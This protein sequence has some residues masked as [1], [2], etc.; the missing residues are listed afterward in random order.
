[1][2]TQEQLAFMCDDPDRFVPGAPVYRPYVTQTITDDGA[3]SWFMIE[4]VVTVVGDT[5]MI[6]ASNVFHKLDDTWYTDRAA[7]I[8]F[9]AVEMEKV[10]RTLVRAALHVRCDG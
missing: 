9:V 6:A 5:P 8:D 7:A 10:G 4:G 1:M 2:E 3:L